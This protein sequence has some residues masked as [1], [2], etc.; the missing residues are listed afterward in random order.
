[1]KPIK[2]F[3][4]IFLAGAVLFA[5]SYY[6]PQNKVKLWGMELRIYQIPEFQAPPIKLITQTEIRVGQPDTLIREE[7]ALDTIP[8][9][10][11]TLPKTITQLPEVITDVP[12]DIKLTVPATVKKKF[13]NQSKKQINRN[14]TIWLEQHKFMTHKLFYPMIQIIFGGNLMRNY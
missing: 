12:K 3:I 4:F 14:R 6:S 2:S 13:L 7:I 9:L 8:N 1:M 10:I 5:I 11:A